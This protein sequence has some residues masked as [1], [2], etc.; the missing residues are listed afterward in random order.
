MAGGKDDGVIFS[1]GQ[2]FRKVDRDEIYDVLF[3]EI[4][5]DGWK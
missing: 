1:K 2:P 5:K 4:E 3:E